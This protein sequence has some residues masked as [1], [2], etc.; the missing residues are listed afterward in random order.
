VPD[1]PLEVQVIRAKWAG[2]TEFVKGI[3]GALASLIGAAALAVGAW[4]AGKVNTHVEQVHERQQENAASLDTLRQGQVETHERVNAVAQ[5]V[6][7]VKRQGDARMGTGKV[8]EGK[9]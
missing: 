5:E 6:G 8:P 3:G 9:E 7:A 1:E 2:R 4:Y